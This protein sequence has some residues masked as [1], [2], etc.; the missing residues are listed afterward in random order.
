MAE[1]VAQPAGLSPDEIVIIALALA[2][3]LIFIILVVLI[4]AAWRL[5]K[6]EQMAR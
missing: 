5:Y 4:V 2:A 3:M 6:N 1:E